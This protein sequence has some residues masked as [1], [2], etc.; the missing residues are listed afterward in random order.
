[1]TTFNYTSFDLQNPSGNNGLSSF[2]LYFQR[3]LYKEAIYP[4]NVKEPLDTWYD[5]LYYGRVDREQ[6]TITAKYENLQSVPSPAT[7]NLL[8]LNFVADA[9]SDFTI[10]MKNAFLLGVVQPLNANEKLYDMRAYTAYN[11]PSKVYSEYGQ[12]LFN[13]F[14]SGLSAERKN[15]ITNFET[16]VD[17]WFLY[18][19]TVASYIPVTKTNYLI[20]NV[21]NS[22]NSGLSIAIDVGPSEDDAYKYDNWINDR[23]FKFY[24]DSAKKFG[25]TINKNIPWVLTAD[26]FSDACLAYIEKYTDEDNFFDYYYHQTYTEDIDLLKTLTTNAYSAFIKNNPIYEKKSY[27]PNCDKTKVTVLERR[28]LDGS[29]ISN[30]SDKKIIDM[31]LNLRST[32]AQKPIALSK[33]LNR[34]IADIYTTAQ[35]NNQ[36]PLVSASRYINSIY[37]DYIYQTDYLALNPNLINSLDRQIQSGTMMSTGTPTQQS[38]Y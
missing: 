36:N 38:S 9:F 16:F 12:Q 32:E 24:V 5:K 26:L 21:G 1:M 17:A 6:N 37:R 34:R 13:S 28:A 14:V 23:N 31:Y 11:D 33:G 7:S 15:Q 27:L 3:I 25:F 8:C 10:H 20:T 4:R 35:T 22:F 18:L 29:S 30:L 2:A 19:Q